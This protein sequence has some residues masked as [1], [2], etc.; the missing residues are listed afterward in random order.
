MFNRKLPSLIAYIQVSIGTIHSSQYL[1]ETN[2]S[3]THK[4]SNH[5]LLRPCCYKYRSPGPEDLKGNEDTRFKQKLMSNLFKT[6]RDVTT[7][8]HFVHIYA[9]IY[10]YLQ[11]CTISNKKFAVIKPDKMLKPLNKPTEAFFS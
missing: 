10:T 6:A 3:T 2:S 7:Y 5:R 8:N 9:Y 11:S 4:F 1:S